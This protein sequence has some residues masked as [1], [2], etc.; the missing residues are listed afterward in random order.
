MRRECTECV[1]SAL[2]SSSALVLCDD[3]VTVRRDYVVHTLKP[4]IK[5]KRIVFLIVYR[6][7]PCSCIVGLSS[8]T[9]FTEGRCGITSSGVQLPW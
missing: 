2:V 1:V 7:R 5:H 3:V 8:S 6:P 9:K 4:C